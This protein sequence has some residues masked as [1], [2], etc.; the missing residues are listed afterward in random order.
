[1]NAIVVPSGKTRDRS[2]RFSQAVVLF[3]FT[4]TL[5]A[6]ALLL[7]SV[8]PMFAKMV[9]P[10]LGGS[11]TVWAVSMCFFQGMLLVGYGYAYV[12]NR[13]LT[14]RAAIIVHVA[15]LVTTCL[16][17]PFGLPATASAPPVGDAYLWLMGVLL[18]GV[19]LP[20]FAI[21]GNAPLLQ[22]WFS[23]TGHP[24]ARDPYFLYRA[25]N[26]GSL[27]ALLAYPIILEPSLGLSAQ[28][29]LWAA[30]FF[31]LA[32]LISVCGLMLWT[33]GAHLPR[34]R[35][36]DDVGSPR[37]AAISWSTRALWV[38]L[39]FI[40]S[41]LI[42]GVT[43]YISTDVASAPF[44]WVVPLAL[45]LLTFVLVFRDRL[46]FNYTWL[47]ELLPIGVLGMVLT[48]G[49]LVSSVFALVAFFFSSLVCH[50][51]LYKRRPPSSHLTEFYLWMSFGGVLG[52]VFAALIAPHLFNSVFEFSLLA[53]LALLC[54]PGILLERE[55]PLDLRRMGLI[56]GCGTVLIGTYKLATAAGI[57]TADRS[58]LLALIGLCCVGLVIIRAWP[59]Q[60]VALVLTMIAAAVLNPAYLSTLHIERSFFGTH[61]V[62]ITDNGTMRTLLHGTTIHGAQRLVDERG[63]AL[64][65]PVPATYYHAAGPMARGVERARAWSV[66]K[67]LPMRVGVVGLGAGSMA[68]YAE[69]GE[70]WRFF[71]ID[72][73]VARI[74]RNPK[75]FN[76]LPTCQ[77]DA[78]V[79]IGDARLT[80][81]F[82]PD[83]SFSYLV[84]DAFS[85]DSIPVHLM[86]TEAITLFAGKLAPEGLLALHVSN[87][88]LDL[89]PALASTISKVPGLSAIYVDDQRPAD[90]LA[91]TPSQVV[92]VARNPAVLEPIKA[93]SGATPLLPGAT[94][95]WTDDYSNILA[96]LW[97]KRH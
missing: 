69:R 53:L 74:A 68:C 84:I 72:P 73:A 80:L 6:S 13:C 79:I 87:R 22:A 43:T 47:C 42:V 66:A 31:A 49:M 65:R 39:S 1:M 81:G 92:F 64:E 12:L 19:G 2:V 58:H 76:F 32:V 17:L 82:E 46:P 40:P 71:E 26:I 91:A 24:H 7:F 37:A 86:T 38:A 54:R 14:D 10:K 18:V 89:V 62:M 16:A 30:G 25:S 45:F 33:N 94:A 96:A 34:R 50:H 97:S 83:Q 85:S 4:G 48:Q 75:L 88:H 3:V 95:A 59:E 51:E 67:G 20:F 44:L 23:R 78:P 60:R 77:P 41:G 21:A 15:L 52:G 28:S 93:W 35:A 55:V 70:T 36:T 57:L 61:R 9:L 27:I 5:F 11:P 29:A 56:V 90:T 8:Q 63:R